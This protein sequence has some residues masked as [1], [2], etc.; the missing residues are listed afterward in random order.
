MCEVQQP[1]TW[2]ELGGQG[3]GPESHQ[4]G[5][6]LWAGED[7]GSYAGCHIPSKVFLVFF[8]I[9]TCISSAICVAVDT[10][11]HFGL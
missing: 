9:F 3:G 5:S 10:I 6:V 11:L 8:R 1:A 4:P 2:L 7:M